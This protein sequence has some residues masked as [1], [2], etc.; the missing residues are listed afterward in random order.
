[1]R[2]RSLLVLLVVVL[3]LGAFVWFYERKLPTTSERKSEEKKV[4]ADLKSEDV[5]EVR[6][7]RAGAEVRL[8]RQGAAPPGADAK[9]AVDA[10]PPPVDVEWRLHAPKLDAR[11]D[12]G[13]VDGLLGS[14]LALE[15]ARTLETA[16]RRQYGLQPPEA[17]VT[18]LTAKGNRVLEVGRALPATDQR[19][20]AV[21]GE[22]PVYAVE[23]GFWNDVSKPAGEW[24]TK[25]LFAGSQEEVERVTLQHDAAR[26][27]LAR[28]GEEPWIETPIADRA[29]SDR[30]G[31]LLGALGGLQAVEF[32]DQPPQPLA[33]LG[34]EPPQSI[35]EVV[36]RGQ[37]KPFRLA[38][39]ATKGEGEQQVR[40]ALADG[41][42]V[43]VHAPAV[44]EAVTRAPD[45][46]RS[47]AWSSFAVYDVERI[48][49]KSQAGAFVLTR[50]EADWKR[51]GVKIFYGTVS[52]LL[53]ALADARATKVVPG[54]S[55][56]VVASGP[57]AFT[58]RLVGGGGKEQTLQLWPANAEA[59]PARASGRDV[60]L[61]MPSALPGD[62]ATKIAAV[63]AA[64]PITEKLPA[65]ATPKP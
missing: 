28:R 18:L 31:D 61:L 2:P 60:V 5:R 41:Q 39:G 20:V 59:A 6:I 51:D 14:L 65:A 33:T 37:A 19:A 9:E 45:D 26:V 27:L 23:S 32:V 57:A 16:D 38:L 13:A 3:A 42:L 7:A 30:W 55:A 24:R 1:V 15:K 48:E 50:S 29:D 62:V 21:A 22:K 52:D 10:A 11:A 35:V 58:F 49:V 34:L 44:D 56:T 17:R 63:R 8:E 12:R 36:R 25:E 54:P 4:L 53:A 40:W 46:W 43:T 64:K 47:R